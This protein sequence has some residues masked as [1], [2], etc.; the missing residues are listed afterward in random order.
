MVKYTFFRWALVIFG[1]TPLPLL[2]WLGYIAGT[3]IWMS[4]TRMSKVARI[5]IDRCFPNLSKSERRKLVRRSLQ[6][7]GKTMLE[8]SRYW[9]QA[10][11]TCLGDIKFIEDEELRAQLNHPHD[12][13][14]TKK[15]RSII[16]IA[17]H[18]GNWELMNHYLGIHWPITHMYQPARPRR[19]NQLIQ[20]CREKTGTEFV[21]ADMTGI[22]TQLKAL[23]HGKNIGAMPDQEPEPHTGIFVD[24]FGIP[25]LTSQLVA[26]LCL[27]TDCIPV[28]ASCCRLKSVRGFKI[29][30]KPLNINRDCSLQE[31]MKHLNEGIE[32]V[33]REYPEQYLW[34]YKRFRTRPAGEEEFYNLQDPW[35]KQLFQ[36]FAVKMFSGITRYLPLKIARWMGACWGYVAYWFNFRRSRIT[37]IN[38]DLCLPE[39]SDEQ[40]KK[41]RL[42]SL[43]ELGKTA[44]ENGFICSSGDQLFSNVISDIKGLEHLSSVVTTDNIP[45]SKDR[46]AISGV[47][48]TKQGIVV[49]TPPQGNREVVMR[50]LGKH[51]STFEYYHPIGNTALDKFIRE[52]RYGMGVTLHPHTS[53]ASD[54]LSD[55]LSKGAVVTLCPDQ[56]PRLRGGLFVPF[57]NVPALTTL[58]LVDILLRGKA[59]LV[60]GIALR[61]P[62]GFQLA[63]SPIKISPLMSP[64]DILKSVNTELEQI[65]RNAPPQ[66]RWSDKRF[67]IRPKG[68]SKIYR[69]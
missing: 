25:A 16:I 9:T 45:F 3:I 29:N 18:L 48:N 55:H 30:L 20:S 14:K 23:A 19:L 61:T 8:T 35:L 52:S 26:G 69:S 22:K 68:E 24:F 5:N 46:D 10:N 4:G 66:Y 65:I 49:L 33:I 15:P 38:L 50:Y 47:E 54:N 11:K 57:F 27:K 39:I 1:K 7:T 17:P 67:N 56:Q 51:Y 21:P 36:G 42:E 63:F 32:A 64:A 60:C 43:Q 13:N 44:A 40:K 37:R 62:L 12:L 41:L 6:E 58:A 59:K 53:E 31:S 2:Q 28:I 34:S